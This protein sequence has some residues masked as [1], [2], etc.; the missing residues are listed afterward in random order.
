MTSAIPTGQ[1]GT[2]KTVWDGN[3]NATT[4]T[5]W[6]RGIPKTIQYADGNS[7][8]GEVNDSGWITS[9]TDENGYT[10][11]YGY[12][13]LGQLASVTYPEGDSTPWADTTRV[14]E[15]ITAS[16][17]YV[18]APGH[19]RET[20][21]TGDARNIVYYDALLSPPAIGIASCSEGVCQ[22]V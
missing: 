16:S 14:V 19:W 15:Q 7:R 6:K 1:R 4:L 18:I 5:E 10:T 13:W 8:F 20:N 3:S 9:L 11:T 2:V 12:D 17:E 22:Y 21:S